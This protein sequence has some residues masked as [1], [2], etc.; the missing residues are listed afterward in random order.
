[1]GLGEGSPLTSRERFLEAQGLY[2]QSLGGDYAAM[3]QAAQAYLR[4]TRAYHGVSPAAVAIFNEVRSRLGSIANAGLAATANAPVFSS[5]AIEA[6]IDSTTGAVNAVEA[7]MQAIRE[8]AIRDFES[9]N[10]LLSG[11]EAEAAA[12][13]DAQIE[14]LY[15]LRDNTETQINGIQVLTLTVSEYVGSVVDATTEAAQ[16]QQAQLGAIERR[17]AELIAAVNAQ[18]DSR[19]G[20]TETQTQVLTVAMEQMAG[21]MAEL[22]RG[23]ERAVKAVQ[24]K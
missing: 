12:D 7:E 18:T 10:D 17:L 6:A 19:S 13:R 23:V 8:A 1:M 14:A 22:G 5:P 16:K 24:R 21:G 20:D 4:E 11:I 3:Q 15:R 2:Q 9:L